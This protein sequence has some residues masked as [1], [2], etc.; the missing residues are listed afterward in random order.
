MFTEDNPYRTRVRSRLIPTGFRPW[1]VG[2]AYEN[3][4]FPQPVNHY[5]YQG[6]ELCDAQITVSEGHPFWSGVKDTEGI[7]PD[8]GGDFLTTYF[9]PIVDRGIYSSSSV[10]WTSSHRFWQHSGHLIPN[11]RNVYEGASI[12]WG[13]ITRDTNIAD[14]A[15]AY[16]AMRDSDETLLA[17][18][19]TAIARTRPDQ[20]PAQVTQF[21]VEL[22]RDG[23]P[24]LAK[25]SKKEFENVLS[26]FK[27][28][29]VK[30]SP[31]KASDYF[32][33]NQFG[34]KPFV[35]DLTAVSRMAMG[36]N[37][38]L[39]NLIANSGK[40]IRRRYSF[41]HETFSS[42]RSHS[43]VHNV[44]GFPNYYP[45]NQYIYGTWD[46]TPQE[47]RTKRETWFSG[48]YRIY[49]PT[50]LE[51]VS[52]LKASLDKARWDYGLELDFDTMWN[53]APWSWLLDWQFNLGD[54]ITNFAKW[55]D[56]AVVLH[57]GYV[58]QK[59][60]S[61]YSIAFDGSF[62][63]GTKPSVSVPSQG[64]KVTTK[65]R[66]RATPYGFGTSAGSLS[67]NQKAILAAI[68]ITRF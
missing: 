49:M 13:Y 14:L 40:L 61:E 32:L 12:G 29:G 64:L 59:T 23:V 68:G 53:L 62:I 26:I 21:L 27:S 11:T 36:G 47:I 51:P 25:L 7:K 54:V 22:K 31:K 28:R 56:D 24:F 30:K 17:R 41:P 2:I 1:G 65:R 43:A 50:D 46:T 58:M 9:Q 39:D 34:L 60:V 15:Q 16:P 66:L 5:E 44:F 52:R 48:A 18:G 45:Y 20:S 19:T 38:V 10:D 6:E 33:E 63:E 4:F 55:S 37:S 3:G 67:L 35:S 8:Q 57:Y 42:Q